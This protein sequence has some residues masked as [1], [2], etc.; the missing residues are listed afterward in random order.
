VAVVRR[1]LLL[2]LVA[3]SGRDAGPRELSISEVMT[4]NPDE[5]GDW[6]ELENLT[7]RRLDLRGL[8]L[9]DSETKPMKHQLEHDEPILLP[10]RERLVFYAD[11]ETGLGPLHLR[12]RLSKSGESIVVSTRNGTRIDQVAVPPMRAGQSY[13]RVGGELAVCDTPTPQAANACSKRELPAD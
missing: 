6:I 4:S 3:C 7:D 5:G 8:W 9:S 2:L 1:G 12:F 13:A 11:G 10:P